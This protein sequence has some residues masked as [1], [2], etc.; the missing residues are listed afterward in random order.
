VAFKL[1]II[2]YL[3]LLSFSLITFANNFS[4]QSAFGVAPPSE[5]E[6]AVSEMK[7]RT[8]DI[9]LTWHPPPETVD[10]YELVKQKNDG[11]WSKP[12]KIAGYSYRVKKLSTGSWGFKVRACNKSGCGAYSNEKWVDVAIPPSSPRNV[13]ASGGEGERVQQVQPPVQS[14]PLSVITASDNPESH[15]TVKVQW[16]APDTGAK[17]S[18]YEIE[19][20]KGDCATWSSV[21]MGAK[22][23]SVTL[24][25]EKNNRLKSGSYKFRVRS[26]ATG[27][28]LTSYSK[29]VA[30]PR[31]A[32]IRKGLINPKEV[33]F[34]QDS[35]KP[36]FSNGRKV[37]DLIQSLKEGKVTAYD[38]PPI[39]VFGR[40]GKI[41]SLDNRRLKAF[42][43]ANQPIRIIPATSEELSTRSF[44]FTS[45]NDGTSI[46]IREEGEDR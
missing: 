10:T 26:Y 12:I 7:S 14:A 19:Q 21:Y 13:T 33:R 9:A 4:S 29:W 44:K 39:R 24:P 2:T 17:V 42:Q 25:I 32:V 34:T 31:I 30:S 22:A 18:G 46:R 36:T 28:R 37:E 1:H 8:G 15:G 16:E 43:E 35:I 40:D 23:V 11:V 3:Y 5:V 20:C 38:V 27:G 6:M 41:Y 45:R